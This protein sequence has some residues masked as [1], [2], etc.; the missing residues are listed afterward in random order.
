MKFRLAL[1]CILAAPTTGMAADYS[2]AGFDMRGAYDPVGGYDWSG[3]YAGGHVGYGRGGASNDWSSATQ[4]WTV[5]GDIDYQSAMGGG[6]V[7]YQQQFDRFV[8]GIE[9]D[10]SLGHYYGDDAKFAGAVNA[11][12]IDGLGTLRG[13]L[14]W[15]HDNL[16]IYGTAGVAVASFRKSEAGKPESNPQLAPGWTAGG[17]LEMAVNRDW[18]L[19]AE[20]LHVQ[21]QDVIS[22]LG[23]MHRANAPVLDIVRIGASYRF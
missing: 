16:M 9:A 5:D 7:G 20:Y 23:Y 2:G 14:G 4:P 21:L 12:E 13:R 10:L 1:L 19:R 11:I 22:D 8:G 18:R 17:G 15:T 6:Q 3:F